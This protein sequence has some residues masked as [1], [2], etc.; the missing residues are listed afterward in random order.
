MRIKFYKISILFL[1]ITGFITQSA[2]SQNP[3]LDKKISIN[4]S[5]EKFINALEEISKIA[6][7]NFS[8]NAEI[9]SQNI[10]ITQKFEQESIKNIL[11]KLLKNSTLT[12]KVIKNQ[13]IIKKTDSNDKNLT[14]TIRGKVVDKHSQ[15]PLIGATIIL[16]EIGGPIGAISDE[17]GEFR[18]KKI[19]VGRKTLQISYIG[20]ET[21]TLAN[22]ILNSGKE[23]IL[24]IELEEKIITTEEIVVKGSKMIGI[25]NVY[26]I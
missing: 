20:F 26:T 25:R 17:N 14:Q 21:V 3:V 24:N 7:I 8:Y 19:S 9:I 13:V 2:N 6:S 23:L 16:L 15:S 18:L 1:I 12:Y 11:D 5:N 10:R 4:F 22:L